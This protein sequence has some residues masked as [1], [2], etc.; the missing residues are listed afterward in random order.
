[1]SKPSNT[2]Y[3]NSSLEKLYC[4][5]GCQRYKDRREIRDI[6]GGYRAGEHLLPFRT[7]KLSPASPMILL[8]QVGKQEAARLDREPCESEALFL[9]PNR[10]SNDFKLFYYADGAWL[11]FTE[12]E[13]EN[14]SLP[15]SKCRMIHFQPPTLPKSSSIILRGK[16]PTHCFSWQWHY[17]ASYLNA[18]AEQVALTTRTTGLCHRGLVEGVAVD[19]QRKTWW[20]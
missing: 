12:W 6:F 10:F 7:E 2:N 17:C 15:A 8:H 11:T 19:L 20:V 5:S 13:K 4:M 18:F 16:F 9:C 3:P 14:R 1:M